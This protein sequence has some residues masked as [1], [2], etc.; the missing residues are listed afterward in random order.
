[1]KRAILCAVCAAALAGCSTV[2][3]SEPA[4]PEG[5]KKMVSDRRVITDGGLDE[6]VYIAGINEA[7]APSGNI[8]IQAE[9]VNRT[10]AYRQFNYRFEWLD[11][12]GMMISTPAPVWVSSFIEGGESKF[13][14]ATAPSARAKDFRLKLLGDVRD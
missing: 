13:I 10:T 1:M 5:V 11:E 8:R 12:N 14:A 3:M 7:R 2:N 6:I 4:N 9:L